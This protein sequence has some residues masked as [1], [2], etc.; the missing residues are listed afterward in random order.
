M[1]NFAGFNPQQTLTLLQKM[2]YTGSPQQDEMDAYIASQPGAQAQLGRYAEMAQKRLSGNYA[3]GGLVTAVQSAMNNVTTANATPTTTTPEDQQAKLDAAQAKFAAAQAAAAADP[4][5]EAKQKALQTAQAELQAANT[6]YSTTQVPSATEATAGAVTN[7]TGMVTPATVDQIA[8]SNDQLIAAGTG[9]AA[10]TTQATATTVDQTAT[11]ATPEKTEAVTV[12]P[13]LVTDKVDETLAGVEAATADPS[14]KATVR[15]QLEMLMQ[16]FEGGETPPWASGSMREAM[17]I[18]Q[19]RG[20]GASSMAGQAIVQAAMESA[21]AI[22]GQDAQTFANF[23]LTNLNNEQQTTIF[24]T[25]QR[26]ASLMSDQAV[27]NATSQF[28]AANQNQVNQFF[29]DLEATASRFNAEQINGIAKFNAGEENAI[30]QFNAQLE[31]QREQ[32]N[33]QNDLI[34]AQANTKWRQ[35]LATFNTA[36]QNEANME[37]AR[38]SNNLTQR[39]LDHIWQ[40]ERDLMSYAFASSES[41]EDRNL[42]LLLANK[43]INAEKDAQKKQAIGYLA[44]RLL[45]G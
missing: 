40:T 26:I 30:E 42:Q 31:A 19:K 16:D 5:N 21:I 7:P 23:E 29:A 17:A 13:T 37:F 12:D 15:G 25:Q 41:L 36:A 10:P 9:Q 45:F 39:A 11:A 28:N 38:T 24:K 8:E 22:A 2:G 1:P 44:G 6:S 35:D 27:E 33:A 4:T 43:S 34:I 20:L 18:M 14:A 3:V 32:F